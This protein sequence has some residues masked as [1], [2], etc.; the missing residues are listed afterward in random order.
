[1]RGAYG[2]IS[3]RSRYDAEYLNGLARDQFLKALN[4]VSFGIPDSVAIA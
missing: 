2:H 1:V 3:I 4:A